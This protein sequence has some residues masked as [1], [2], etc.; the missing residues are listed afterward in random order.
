VYVDTPGRLDA[1]MI[2]RLGGD[3]SRLLV[4]R[5]KNMREGLES[6]RIL[7]RAGASMVCFDLSG[8]GDCALDAELP[9]LVHRAE[10]AACIALFVQDAEADAAALRFYASLVVALQRK[11]WMLRPDGDL[12]GLDLE[13]VTVKNRLAPPGRRG[14]WVLPYVFP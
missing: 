14:R 5:P 1:D 4:V 8:G 6:A 9:Q 3:L 12:L 13:A 7:A 10:E 11:A 2:Y